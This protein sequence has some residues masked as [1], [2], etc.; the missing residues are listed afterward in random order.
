[1]VATVLWRELHEQRTGFRELRETTRQD[2]TSSL[3]CRTGACVRNEAVGQDGHADRVPGIADKLAQCMVRVAAPVAFIW[4]VRRVSSSTGQVL[5]A[6]VA[7]VWFHSQRAQEAD[8]RVREIVLC[9]F[10]AAARLVH[11]TPTAC[12]DGGDVG[13]HS[14]SPRAM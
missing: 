11:A 12:D 7:D 13:A 5:G 4:L 10:P 6:G 9:G 8:G 14:G 2:V 1:M 3:R